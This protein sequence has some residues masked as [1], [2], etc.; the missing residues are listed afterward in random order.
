MTATRVHFT[1]YVDTKGY[2]IVPAR[3]PPRQAGQS[4]ADWALN[5][6]P[7]DWAEARIVGEGGAARAVRL[8]NYPLLYSAF[9]NV[10]T[11]EELLKFIT[12]YGPLTYARIG[13]G[14]GDE[15]PPLLDE[16][17]SMRR[18]IKS[19]GRKFP[20]TANIKASLSTDKTKG[21]V[22]VKVSP[23]RLL[24]ALWLQLGQALAE[25]TEWRECQHCH[26]WFP[27]GGNSGKRLVSKF[28]TEEHRI[29]FNSLE[30]SR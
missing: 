16:A 17:A 13:R 21:T 14:K 23:V 8:S 27:V 28:C 12:E 25:G 26:E 19:R 9:A 3:R 20:L 10:K 18:C 30:R 11:P 4:E 29:K 24:D 1:S 22:S 5:S 6:T 7:R 2:K 15:I